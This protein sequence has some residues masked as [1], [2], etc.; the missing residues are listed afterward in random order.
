MPWKR[1]RRGR[2]AN[3][4]SGMAAVEFAIVAPLFF[5]IIFGIM[6]AGRVWWAQHALEY[7]VETTAR[8]ALV[9]SA[10]TSAE[11]QAFAQSNMAGL[12]PDIVSLN[13]TVTPTTVSGVNMIQVRGTYQFTSIAPM[14]ASWNSITLTAD[15]RLAVPS[16]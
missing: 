15:A 16:P 3:D 8:Y 7:A 14:P 12:H 11:L 1:K 9:N 13:V 6:E 5:L 10:A 4:Q 2:A